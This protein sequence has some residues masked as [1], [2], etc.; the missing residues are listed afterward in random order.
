VVVDSQ[1]NVGQ[2]RAQAAKRTNGI[3][4][5]VRSST[6]SRSTEVIIPT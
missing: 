2:Q 5:Y 4:A 6:A 3:Q 1:L